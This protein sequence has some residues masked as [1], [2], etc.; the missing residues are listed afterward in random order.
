MAA[1]DGTI[2]CEGKGGGRMGP[3]SR[4]RDRA[5]R[6]AFAVRQGGRLLRPAPHRRPEASARRRAVSASRDRNHESRQSSEFARSNQVQSQHPS[7]RRVPPRRSRLEDARAF[8]PLERSAI[9]RAAIRGDGGS[10]R[11]A[12]HT[13]PRSRRISRRLDPALVARQS[14]PQIL[15][16]AVR[17]PPDVAHGRRH[18]ERRRS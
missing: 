3:G 11:P 9:V 4:H 18:A 1:D 13:Q 2:E 6:V 17:T 12:R 16:G 7:P 8:R 15:L 14:A 5:A 10:K